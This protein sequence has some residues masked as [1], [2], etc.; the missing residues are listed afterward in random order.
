MIVDIKKYSFPN[1][2]LIAAL[3][4]VALHIYVKVLLGASTIRINFS[5]IQCGRSKN[6][7]SQSFLYHLLLFVRLK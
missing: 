1:G 2:E 6:K 5:E 3:S 4:N 7:N